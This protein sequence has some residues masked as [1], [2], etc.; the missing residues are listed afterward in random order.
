MNPIVMRSL[1]GIAPALPKTDVGTKAGAAKAA[2]TAAD[3]W[4]R[5]WRRVN[6]GTEFIIKFCATMRTAA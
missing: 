6:A 3:V 1:G 5:K 2:A 4:R